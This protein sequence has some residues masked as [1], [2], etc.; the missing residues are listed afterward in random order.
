MDFGTKFPISLAVV[1]LI[2]SQLI[3]PEKVQACRL[4]SSMTSWTGVCLFENNS[5]GQWRISCKPTPRE[6]NCRLRLTD[7][8]QTKDVLA[9]NVTYLMPRFRSA[10]YVTGFHSIKP[11]KFILSR[12]EAVIIF[13]IS[14]TDSL[15]ILWAY[16]P[17][18]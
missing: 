15:T 2:F 16:I 11:I 9:L 10:R 12:N 13:H 5:A 14:T 17:E 3:D 4:S 1:S 8:F 7:E 18:G 6:R